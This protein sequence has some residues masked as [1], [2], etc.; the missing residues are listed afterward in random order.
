VS[1]KKHNR[2][3]H[4]AQKHVSGYGPG[5]AFLGAKVDSKS[6]AE[7]ATKRG[8]RAAHNE[9]KHMGFREL[10]KR[11]SITDWLLMVFTGVLA[12]V[13]IYQ[14]IVIRGQI[15][16]SDRQF[17]TSH[18]PWVGISSVDKVGPLIF[19]S[20]GVHA[21][22]DFTIKN[23]GVSPAI[24]AIEQGRLVVKVFTSN[25]LNPFE[26]LSNAPE[27]VC[28]PDLPSALHQQNMGLFLLPGDAQ[29]FPSGPLG[30]RKLDIPAGDLV[31]VFWVGCISYFDDADQPHGTSFVYQYIALNGGKGFP[32]KGTV[33]GHVESFGL[34]KAY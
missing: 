1:K 27:F 19:D 25:D 5:A 28:A 14:F 34:S 21:Q 9:E 31:Q 12:A 33:V 32:P 10:I 7:N 11:P 16:Q 24:N 8:N 15:S 30:A 20:D 13:S 22:I 6:E 17:S 26:R 29:P 18:R 23:G 4:K 2:K 3:R